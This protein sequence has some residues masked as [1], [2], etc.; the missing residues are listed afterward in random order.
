MLITATN[1]LKDHIDEQ[2]TLTA[3]CQSSRQVDRC[4][5]FSYASLLVRYGY[6]FHAGHSTRPTRFF[7]LYLQYRHTRMHPELRILSFANY[8]LLCYHTRAP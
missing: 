8:H 3:S 6:D 5:G 2:H 1:Y 4:G 7:K